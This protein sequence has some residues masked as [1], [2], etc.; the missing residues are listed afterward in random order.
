MTPE[1][2][3]EF[4]AQFKRSRDEVASWPKWMQDAARTATANFP[5]GG[6]AIKTVAVKPREPDRYR[7]F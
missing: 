2:T 3:K 7:P 6:V 1:Q 5:R 4:L